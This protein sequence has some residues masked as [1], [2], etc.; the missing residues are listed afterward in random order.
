MKR[1]KIETIL[2][3]LNIV[4]FCVGL[5][6]AFNHLHEHDEHDTLYVNGIEIKV[7]DVE[8]KG[9]KFYDYEVENQKMQV[10]AVLADDGTVR[11]S[12]N[13]CQVCFGS[14]KGYFAVKDGMLECQ[15]CGNK[16]SFNDVEVNRGG[17][18]PIPLTEKK[19][20]GNIIIISHN[21]FVENKKLFS[22]WKI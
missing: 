2:V 16:F 6:F 8:K 14:G 22:R 1:K 9:Y 18:N 12:W 20:E 3:V 10:I 5:L 21:T 7:E 15:N 11:T 13:T 19:I 17:C 4:F